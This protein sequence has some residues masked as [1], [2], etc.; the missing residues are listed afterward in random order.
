MIKA[1]EI[2]SYGPIQDT[3]RVPLGHVTLIHGSNGSGKTVVCRAIATALTAEGPVPLQPVV[4]EAFSKARVGMEFDHPI[5]GDLKLEREFSL[6]QVEN[7]KEISFDRDEVKVDGK[8]RPD[9]SILPGLV[10]F[11]Y[12]SPYRDPYSGGYGDMPE[13]RFF[14]VAARFLGFV[15]ASSDAARAAVS[16]IIRRVNQRQDRAF[17]KIELRDGRLYFQ[18]WESDP[19]FPYTTSGTGDKG[20]LLSDFLLEAAALLGQYRHVLLILDDFPT[21]IVS[22]RFV[23]RYRQLSSPNIQVIMTTVREGVEDRLGADLIVELEK[24]GDDDNSTRVGGSRPIPR[25]MST[26]IEQVIESYKS[27]SEAEFL[28]EFVVPALRAL[29][30]K[31][32]SRVSHHG[33]GEYGF[34]I[35]LFHRPV[36]A[37]RIAYFGAQVKAGNIGSK[38]SGSG[39]VSE[40]I[41]Q[42][43]K[44]LTFKAVDPATQLRTSADYALAIISGRLSADAQ[45]IFDDAFEADRRIVLWDAQRFASVLYEAGV[46]PIILA[47]LDRKRLKQDNFQ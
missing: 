13:N 26:T 33:A 17:R 44:M 8:I 45:R 14:Q 18:H 27:G 10:S 36:F 6:K 32:V 21:K 41:D 34:D 39:T 22:D 24:P 19:L 11:I 7:K 12:L 29:D 20:E 42:L 23:R 47:S 1:I 40:L 37:G 35:Q 2:S 9:I 46:W 25:P 28:E 38:S 16:E 31:Q 3:I 30:F 15:D 43:K 4:V 5:L